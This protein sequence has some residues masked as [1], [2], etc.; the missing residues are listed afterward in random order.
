M[1]SNEKITKE[2]KKMSSTEREEL[3]KK[4]QES[5]NSLKSKTIQQ[6][7]PKIVDTTTVELTF[8]DRILIFI[9]SLFGIMSFE[10][11]LRRKRL[12]MIKE[13]VASMEPQV[14]NTTTKALYPQFG[15]YIYEIFSIVDAINN[16]L[17]ITILNSNV[18]DNTNLFERKTC[19]EYLFEFL[20]NTRS[21]FGITDL[22]TIL[23]ET[24]SI[25]RIFDRIEVEVENSVASLDQITVNRANKIYT[26][27]LVFVDL[28]KEIN[29][30]KILKYF[31]DDKGKISLRVIP[32]YWLIQE[33]EKLCN[34]LSETDIT[35]MIVDV[36]MALKKYID[37]VMDK[38]SYEYGAFSKVS[39][40]LSPENLNKTYDIVDKLNLTNILCVL[41]DDPD[42]VPLFIVPDKSLV[43]VYK[44]VVIN[45][46]KNYASKIIKEMI[47]EKTN[48][49]FYL[50]GKGEYDVKETFTSI[51]TEENNEKLVNQKLTHF[52]YAT[53]FLV[54]YSFYNYY[55]KPFFREAVNDIIVNG[56]FKEKYL[57]TSLMSAMNGIDEMGKDISNFIKE[58]SKGGEY[59]SY[60]SKFFEDPTIVKSDST[61]RTLQQKISV[62]NN[63]AGSIVLKCNDNVQQLLKYLKFVLDDYSSL[64]PEY[65]LNVKTIKGVYN[66][67]LMETISKGKEVLE[68]ISEVLVFFA[69]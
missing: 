43:N 10:D 12:K 47:K 61:K 65:I 39:Q 51:Y 33:L 34:I 59:Y 25:K 3:R 63:L 29:F 2:I 22:K 8:W 60:I 52:V 17:E 27:L 9:F 35:P 58:T 50:L 19:A 5:L 23:S 36:I 16:L 13:K 68:S 44:D 66:K 69:N 41:K 32:D 45:K 62:V 18:W 31:L 53:A 15:K 28:R 49:F 64:S 24:K 4:M 42:Y 21:L 55:W 40:I 6:E 1:A 20:T 37:E 54:V 30:K 14:M 7:K 57:K 56:I 48:V 11:Y 38:G 46:S 26:R 67:V